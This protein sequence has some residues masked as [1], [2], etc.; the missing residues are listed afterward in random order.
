RHD[1]QH[2]CRGDLQVPLRCP[3]GSADQRG[4]W[5][6]VSQLLPLLPLPR[7]PGPQH[8]QVHPAQATILVPPAPSCKIVC[9]LNCV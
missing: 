1:H 3:H 9:D 7:S 4:R 8:D 5:S 2:D 6:R